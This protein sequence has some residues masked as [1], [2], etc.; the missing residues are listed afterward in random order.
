MGFFPDSDKIIEEEGIVYIMSMTLD[1]ND[2]LY[3]IGITTRTINQ[4]FSENIMS[5]F[6]C[7]RY[8]PRT[9]LR[10]FRKHLEYKSIEKQL[11][12]FLEAKKHDF[13]GKS[14]TGCTEYFKLDP[15]EFSEL[16]IKYDELMK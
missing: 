5:F 8:I 2:R 1:N 12:C 3:K 4:R 11:H 10:R 7:F 14:F 13:D 15:E 6:N 9:D 16:I